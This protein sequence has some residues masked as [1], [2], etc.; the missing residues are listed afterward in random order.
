M[1]IANALTHQFDN[2]QSLE[3]LGTFTVS[4][5]Y[6]AGGTAVVWTGLGI[7]ST[8][9]PLFVQ[10]VGKS[11]YVYEYDDATAKLITREDGAA[12]LPLAE[13][14]TAAYPAAVIADVIKYRAVFKKNV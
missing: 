9:A 3:V 12:S 6:A 10:V 5:N 2:G 13:I 1:A 11:G 14:P 7:K 4:G 8:R